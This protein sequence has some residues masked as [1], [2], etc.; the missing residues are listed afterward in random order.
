VNASTVGLSAMV[1]QPLLTGISALFRTGDVTE[2][3]IDIAYGMPASFTPSLLGHI[4][5]VF[6]GENKDPYTGYS[7]ARVAY[8]KVMNKVPANIGKLPI[9]GELPLPIGKRAL[10]NKYSV[11]GDKLMYT[12]EEENILGKIFRNVFSP[13]FY[14][15]YQPTDEML[16]IIDL[17]EETGEKDVIPRKPTNPFQ[18]DGEKYTLDPKEME[19]MSEWLGKESSNRI[20]QTIPLIKNMDVNAQAEEIMH[21]LN[22]VR[23]EAGAKAREIKADEI[24]KKENEG[25]VKVTYRKQ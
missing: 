12:P 22:E 15:K 4:A 1:D 13:A 2:G 8:N 6:Y 18:Q 21:I 3:L 19:E 23:K 10:P 14:A 25:G 24:N 9:I 5:G 7:K 20:K 16:Y 17:F 11:F